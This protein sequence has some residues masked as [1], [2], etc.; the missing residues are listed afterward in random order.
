[1]EKQEAYKTYLFTAAII[2][3]LGITFSTTMK[4]SVGA[5]GIVFIAI[6]GFFFILGMKKK[7][8]ANDQKKK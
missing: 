5:I 2:I 1:M 3:A 6:G 8:R 4:D 7:Q